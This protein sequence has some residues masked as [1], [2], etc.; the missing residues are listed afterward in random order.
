MRAGLPCPRQPVLTEAKDLNDV[1]RVFGKD[2]K[3]EELTDKLRP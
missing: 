1:L 2:G 3:A